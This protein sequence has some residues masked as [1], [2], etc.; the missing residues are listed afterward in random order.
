MEPNTDILFY[1]YQGG[2]P[3]GHGFYYQTMNPLNFNKVIFLTT[4][5]FTSSYYDAFVWPVTTERNIWSKK[6]NNVKTPKKQK[7]P[8]YPESL[9]LHDCFRLIS[10]LFC[11]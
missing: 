8:S 2:V 4:C 9:V 3:L 1:C 10:I 7:L 5:I 11:R 6:T